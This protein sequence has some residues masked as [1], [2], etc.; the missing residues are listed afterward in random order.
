MQND[1]CKYII[2]GAEALVASVLL[3]IIQAGTN[4]FFNGGQSKGTPKQNC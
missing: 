3:F 2:C 4:I 1:T